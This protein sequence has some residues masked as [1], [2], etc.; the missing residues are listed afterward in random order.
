MEDGDTIVRVRTLCIHLHTFHWTIVSQG[1]MM[2]DNGEKLMKIGCNFMLGGVSRGLLHFD[3][4][5]KALPTIRENLGECYI[6]NFSFPICWSDLWWAGE[7]K[8][9][10]F[11]NTLKCI[12]IWALWG[13]NT[14]QGKEGL[15]AGWNWKWWSNTKSEPRQETIFI[16]LH[17][18]SSHFI[19][20]ENSLPVMIVLPARAVS[21]SKWL[22]SQL[23]HND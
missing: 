5:H 21:G 11:A 23:K 10:I 2:M 8:A 14:I 19:P 22:P 12:G 3:V 20:T 1:L 4:L 6:S 17:F 9:I 15:S 18:N 16:F 13:F 7:T